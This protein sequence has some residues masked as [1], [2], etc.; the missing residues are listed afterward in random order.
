[1]IS[2]IIAESAIERVPRDI[3]NHPSIRRHAQ[4]AERNAGDLLLD[5]S[6]HHDAMKGLRNA[7]KRG[8]PDLVHFALLSAL[9]TPLYSRDELEVYLHTTD[10]LTIT[11]G[12]RVR[13][14]KTYARF[15]TLIVQLQRTKLI[16]T[17]G[18]V[19]LS[20]REMSFPELANTLGSDI[21]VGLSSSGT[22][23]TIRSVAGKLSGIQNA[24]LVIG[25]FP[26][27]DFSQEVLESLTSLYSIGSMQ[28]EAHLVIARLI[29]E[30]EMVRNR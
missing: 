30:L 21:T 26:N 29:Y 7:E 20:L 18:Q 27:G 10:N 1:M 6:Y 23:N 17:N 4:R 19:L 16:E 3:Q 12:K 9:A 22:M 5:R 14:P 28:L 13:L 11:I 2:L 25:G 8:R 15:E 24:T